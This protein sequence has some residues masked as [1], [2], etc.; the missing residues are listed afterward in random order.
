M[1]WDVTLTGAT[2]EQIDARR[3]DIHAPA[4]NDV[5]VH[6]EGEIWRAVT[7]DLKSYDA[8]A[9]ARL[10]RNHILSGVGA[11]PEHWSGGGGDVNRATAAEMGDP[12]HK[13]MAM[14]QQLWAEILRRVARYVIWRRL[15]PLGLSAPDPADPDPELEPAVEWPEM[16]ERDVTRHSTALQ[17]TVAAVSVALGEGL[18]GA[19]TAARLVATVAERLGIEIDPA[20]ELRAAAGRGEGEDAFPAAG[21]GDA[22][23]A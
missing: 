16:V 4:A 17:Q 14:R 1:L 13:Q 18:L 6:N 5:R 2:Q 19:E 7:A 23:A 21:D 11:I 15:D 10:H 9:A 8:S 22:G 3:R 12:A 20:A